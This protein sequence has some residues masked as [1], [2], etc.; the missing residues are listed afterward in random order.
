MSTISLTISGDSGLT[1]TDDFTQTLWIDTIQP[2]G[3]S[4]RYDYAPDSAHIPGSTLLSAALEASSLPLAV[5]ARGTSAATKE[6]AMAELE[7]AVSQ[8]AYTV[9]LT[10][11]G[12]AHEFA[13]DPTWPQWSWDAGMANAFMARAAL[14]I[15][16]NPPGA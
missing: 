5:Y 7:A 11:D 6:A 1:L 15:P 12:Q 14:V 13:A 8:F 10:L 2:P 4:F 16:V 3:F 9:T